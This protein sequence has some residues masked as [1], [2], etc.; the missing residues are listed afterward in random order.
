MFILR[1]ALTKLLDNLF[2]SNIL[3]RMII[4]INAS[5]AKISKLLENNNSI[6]MESNYLALFHIAQSALKFII[7]PID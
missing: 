1:S 3:N 6:I 4:T 2:T 7:A 5:M